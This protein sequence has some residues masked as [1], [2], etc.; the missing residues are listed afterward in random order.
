MNILHS[1]FSNELAVNS[2][3][4]LRSFFNTLTCLVISWFMYN[5]IQ[6]RVV[7]TSFNYKTLLRI[8]L[9]NCNFSLNLICCKYLSAQRFFFY[10]TSVNA[11]CTNGI[12][13]V[14]KRMAFSL[15][16]H[17]LLFRHCLEC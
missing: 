16:V 17:K 14:G 3:K 11:A 7:H 13:L 9:I 15:E 2:N 12:L 8:K 4:D 6:Q 5:I 10:L 1:T